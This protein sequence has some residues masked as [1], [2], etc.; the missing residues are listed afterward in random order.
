[1][2]FE[3]APEAGPILLEGLVSSPSIQSAARPRLE[4]VSPESEFR[5]FSPPPPAAPAGQ[6]D[7]WHGF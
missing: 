1:M 4:R 7:D 6:G 2:D 5:P 3:M